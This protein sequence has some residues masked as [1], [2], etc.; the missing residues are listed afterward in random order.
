MHSATARDILATPSDQSACDAISRADGLIWAEH[1][2]EVAQWNRVAAAEGWGHI[3]IRVEDGPGE[4]Q[5]FFYTYKGREQQCPFEGD[6]EDNLRSVHC[7]AH[8]VQADAQLAGCNDLVGNSESAFLALSHEQWT[9]MEDEFG[10]PALAQRFTPVRLSY[11][12]FC[13]AFFRDEN[14]RDYDEPA[15]EPDDGPPS[16]E[17]MLVYLTHPLELRARELGFNFWFKHALDGTRL[18]LLLVSPGKAESQALF[19]NRAYLETLSRFCVQHCERNAHQLQCI[20]F[21]SEQEARHGEALAT[22]WMKPGA[23][24][25][26]R[27]PV[28]GEERVEPHIAQLAH[29]ASEPAPLGRVKL[30][31]RRHWLAIA[32][33]A[34][35]LAVLTLGTSVT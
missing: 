8:M 16:F 23:C 26:L 6:R 17:D 22:A 18:N 20:A 11:D 13:A 14:V 5:R 31:A 10:A 33:F 4:E 24:P 28:G 35:M 2:D 12:E 29:A 34:I 25:Q 30:F 7:I 3:T 1:G 15:E 32:F 9:R 19:A 21:L 27:F